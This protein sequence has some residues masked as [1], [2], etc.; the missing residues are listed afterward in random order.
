MPVGTA[1]SVKGVL[2][3]QL[4]ELGAEIVLANTYHLHLRPGE[5]VVRGLGG[6]HR[7]IGWQGP[8]LTDSGGYQVFSHGERRTLDEDGVTFRD[9]LEGRSRRLT[10]ESA[11][12]IQEA[13]GSDVMMPLDDCTGHPTER[14]QAMAAMERTLRWLP[15]NMEAR[16]DETAALFGI[17]QGGTF[18]D[19]RERS[20]EQTAAFDMDGYALGGVSVGEGR[21]EIHRVVARFGPRLPWD[22]PRYLMGVGL[23]GDIVDAVRAG[24]DMFDCVVPTRH[25]RNAQLFTSSGRINMRNARFRSEPGPVDPGCGC[26]VCRT[27]SLGYLRHLYVAGEVLASVAGTLHNLWFYL[28]TMRRVREAIVEGRLDALAGKPAGA[29]EGGR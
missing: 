12:A 9:H 26:P 17:V 11:I 14:D 21:E 5:E 8:L 23:P 7:F 25:A 3:W 1:G 6:I 10:P 20:L 27:F 4:V 16:T 19:L 22:R 2:P 29:G 24:F 18:D 13:L 15:R 28:D